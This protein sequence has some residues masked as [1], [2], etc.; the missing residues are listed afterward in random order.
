[1]TPGTKW[2][3][4]AA[5]VQITSQRDSVVAYREVLEVPE[6]VL[7]E[8]KLLHGAAVCNL[9]PTATHAHVPMLPRRTLMGAPR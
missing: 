6:R 1:M 4:F 3:G 9:T 5:P 2:V 8:L 7:L